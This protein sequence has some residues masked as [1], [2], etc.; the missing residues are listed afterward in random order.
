MDLAEQLPQQRGTDSRGQ[1]LSVNGGPAEVAQVLGDA[2]LR[3]W[4][5]DDAAP[6]ADDVWWISLI[7]ID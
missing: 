3:G 2:L 6:D 4:T 7:P 1:T 5:F